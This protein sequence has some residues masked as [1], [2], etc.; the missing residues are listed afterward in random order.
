MIACLG[1][2]TVHVQE[3]CNSGSD[4]A[5][6]S[7]KGEVIFWNSKHFQN[8]FWNKTQSI[9]TVNCVLFQIL[10]QNTVQLTQSLHSWKIPCKY[11]VFNI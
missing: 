6:S 11:F 3:C 9:D 7:S 1:G 10:K 5:S 2:I 8:K 4:T